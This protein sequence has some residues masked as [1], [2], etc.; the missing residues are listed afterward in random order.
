MDIRQKT[1]IVGLLVSTGILMP[2]SKDAHSLISVTGDK[3]ALE[4]NQES[5][6]AVPVAESTKIE[7]KGPGSRPE[8]S[9]I[10]SDHKMRQIDIIKRQKR[11]IIEQISKEETPRKKR[12]FESDIVLVK[13]KPEE[14]THEGADNLFERQHSRAIRLFLIILIAFVAIIFLRKIPTKE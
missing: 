3:P 2:F 9:F 7:G 1:L 6:R 14:K 12:P 10:G 8:P 5:Q 4:D 11:L 13:E